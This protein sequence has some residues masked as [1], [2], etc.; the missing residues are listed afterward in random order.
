VNCE[1]LYTILLGELKW[2]RPFEIIR[3]RREDNA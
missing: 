2:K 3:F 1:E